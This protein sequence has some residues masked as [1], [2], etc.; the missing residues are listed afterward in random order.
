MENRFGVK[1]FFLFIL[2][3][4]VIVMIGLAMEQYDRQYDIVHD[5]QRQSRD[6]LSELVKI[7]TAL[8][9]GI[10]FNGPTSQPSPTAQ[11]PDPFAALRKLRNEGGYDQG[12]WLVQNFGAPVA[13]I[14]PLLS[15][16]IYATI[17]QSRILESLAY[18]DPET[19]DYVPLL[20]TGWQISPDGL[21]I[22]FQIRKGVTFSDGSPFSAD[23]VVFTYDWIMNPKIEDPRDKQAMERVQS[24]SKTNDYEVV[25]KFKEPYFQSFDL[26]SSLGIMSKAFYSKYTPEQFNNSLGLLIGTGP[27]R[28]ETPTD[29]KPTPGRIEMIRNERY[30]GL[31]TS[32]D[33]LV[34]YQV[35]SD[36]TEVVMYGNGDLDVVAVQ[37]QT[38]QLMLKKPDVMAR[39]NHFEYTSPI[40]GYS[41]IAW[42]EKLDG[43]PTVFADKRV[44]QAMTMLTDREG[45]CKNILLGYATP[46]RGPFSPLSKQDDKSLQDWGYDPDKAKALLKEAGFEDRDGSGILSLAD[47]R[48]LSFRLTYGSKNETT[49]RMMRYIKDG[50]ARAGVKAELD[51]EDWTI[52]EQKL[53]T[54][55]FDAISLAWSAGIEDDIYQMFDS[56]QMVEE[57]DDFMSYASPD[58][59]KSIRAART[60]VDEAKRMELWHQCERVLHDDQPYTFLVVR[61][62]LR[63]FD[64]RVQNVHESKTG[65]N[66]VLDWVMPVPWY[67]PAGQQKYKQ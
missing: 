36:A 5:L 62:S 17:V 32:F 10:A 19:L 42:N 52:I 28:M 37:P 20:A 43:T 48:N 59:D 21:T 26:A 40:A 66:F 18:R 57:A 29:W 22:T 65:L 63:F 47:G 16:D 49:E 46:A 14:T 50:Y 58:L 51:P 8:E 6:Q 60:T 61:K 64:K 31:P 54:R 41:Y 55:K 67:V 35:E 45:I 25:F 3:V 7:R 33:R 27:Y 24:V 30:W 38:Y 44:R 53:K 12:D 56:S 39:S 15:T 2:L 9:H 1:D 11:G 4:A 34:F 13:K 23:D